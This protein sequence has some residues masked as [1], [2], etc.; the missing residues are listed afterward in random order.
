MQ[1]LDEQRASLAGK[2]ATERW[3]N[4]V[5]QLL[6]SGVPDVAVRKSTSIADIA[7]ALPVIDAADATNTD[8]PRVAAAFSALGAELGLDWPTD[9]LSSLPSVSRW[10]SM[11]RDSLLDDITTHQSSLAAHRL[12]G[13]G[14]DAR[15]WLSMHG[16][17]AHSWRATI[18][19]AQHAAVPDFSLFSMTCRK[20]NDL[21]RSLIGG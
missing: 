20:L 15:G 4:R 5:Q 6:S 11:E 16:D 21:C 9:Q 1:L 3:N 10:Q 18:E 17:F 12:N 7:V 13:T 14:G 2:Q 8:P 19:D